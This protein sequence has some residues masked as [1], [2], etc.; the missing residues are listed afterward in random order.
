MESTNIGFFA[1]GKTA[2]YSTEKAA[3]VSQPSQKKNLNQST[4]IVSGQV[5]CRKF[6]WLSGMP[7]LTATCLNRLVI[8]ECRRGRSICVNKETVVSGLCEFYEVNAKE[9]AVKHRNPFIP[10]RLLPPEIPSRSWR[11]PEF[12]VRPRILFCSGFW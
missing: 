9:V 1:E 8:R 7:Q 3:M 4:T 5:P 10:W 6:G 12:P 2:P 11:S